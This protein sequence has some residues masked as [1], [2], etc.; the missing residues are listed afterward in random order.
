MYIENLFFESGFLSGKYE[1]SDIITEAVDDN[2]KETKYKDSLKAAKA[3]IKK[4]RGGI[5]AA[6]KIYSNKAKEYK[7]AK[8]IYHKNSAHNKKIM[9]GQIRIVKKN[10]DMN[11]SDK[12]IA[13]DNIKADKRI[14]D[15]EEYGKVTRDPRFKEYRNAYWNGYRSGKAARRIQKYA[16][17]GD[18]VT[19]TRYFGAT[20]LANK[21]IAA[22]KI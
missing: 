11:R 14:K 20:D 2:I 1:D 12:D 18:A 4:Y 15:E 19:A 17:K 13:I 10:K 8:K 16:L 7:D 3:D 9:K 5:L 6:N 21:S 22:A